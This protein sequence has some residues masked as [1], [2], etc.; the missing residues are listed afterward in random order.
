MRALLCAT[1][2]TGLLLG[3]AGPA[4]SQGAP[5]GDPEFHQFDFWIGE[6]IA[7]DRETDRTLGRDSVDAI[8]GG[9]ALLENWTGATGFR[10]TSLNMFDMAKSRWHQAWTDNQGGVTFLEGAFADGRIVMEGSV[11]NPDAADH[12]AMIRITWE[13]VEEGVRQS[14]EKSLDGGK[15]WEA[16]FDILY[17]PAKLGE[18]MPPAP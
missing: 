8:H 2:A 13:P 1:L 6:W 9:C 11:P 17:R 4:L 10:G 16:D 14:G 12:R 3:V 5:C 7:Y 15:S 18:E